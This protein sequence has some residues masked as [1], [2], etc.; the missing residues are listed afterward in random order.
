MKGR[1]AI[2]TNLKIARGTRNSRINLDEPILPVAGFDPPG[3][4]DGEALEFWKEHIGPLVLAGVVLV[5]DR[6]AFGLLCA[7][8][9]AW[10]DEPNRDTIAEYRRMLAEF[11]MT[12]ASRAKVRAEIRPKDSLAD[13]L[14]KKKDG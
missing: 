4:L 11:G 2:P 12:P 8:Y 3:Y 9:A 13:F 5:S 7:S 14:G 1:K 6:H 10:R